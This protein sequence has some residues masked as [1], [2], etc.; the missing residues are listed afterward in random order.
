MTRL[1]V[2]VEG[3]TEESFV[4]EVLAPHLYAQDFSSVRAR[5]IGN[6][7][8]RDRRGGI[9]G[10]HTVRRDIARHLHE[11]RNCIVTTMVDYYG[12]PQH[13]P[14]G[15]PGR[16]QASESA[17]PDKA[18]LVED[19]L[20]ADMHEVMGVDFDVRR[21][22]PH[23]MMHEFEALLF[24]DCERFGIGIGH[25]ELAER[26]QEIRD[27]FQNPE[28]IDESPNQAPSKRIGAIVAGYQKP[29]LGTLAVL[30]IGL[31]RIREQCPPFFQLAESL[32]RPAG[33][34]LN[35]LA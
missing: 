35:G 21:F 28:E 22:V 32:G 24:S 4:N 12:L 33:W 11:D 29:L 13:G 15:W 7:R 30:K 2:H 27:A 14:G 1:L 10:W 17:F 31:P 20:L 23:L 25:P 26:F 3:Q 8:Q 16:T 9:R 34:C 5:L 19:S 18:K 6:A